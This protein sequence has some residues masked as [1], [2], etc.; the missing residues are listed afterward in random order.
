L[1]TKPIKKKEID[2]IDLVMTYHKN[3]TKNN[4]HLIYEGEINQSITKTLT[5]LAEQNLHEENE[6]TKVVRVVYH[7][8]VE[9]LQNIYKHTD[10]STGDGPGKRSYGIIL[11]GHTKDG[12][13]V[14]TG[15]E[16]DQSKKEILIKLLDGINSKS[17]EELNEIYKIQIQDGV[18]S[19]KGG[20]GLGFIDISRKTGSKLDYEFETIDEKNSF[21]ILKTYI[22]K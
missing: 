21:F 18:L 14:S 17:T 13:V 7:V 12:Y 10:P 15:N 4:L 20:A 1:I 9:C 5:S 22:A 11:L 3:M 2:F 8:M 16:V 6:D 19:K